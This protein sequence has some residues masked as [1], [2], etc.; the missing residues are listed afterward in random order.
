MEIPKSREEF[1]KKFEEGQ[2]S[3]SDLGKIKAELKLKRKIED[4]IWRQ[5]LKEK[6]RN[7]E[8]N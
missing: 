5:V 2:Y 7:Y 8:A 4:I 6:R 1:M 3:K